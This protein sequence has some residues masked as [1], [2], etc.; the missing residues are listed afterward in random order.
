MSKDDTNVTEDYCVTFPFRKLSE[1]ARS[2]F[3]IYVELALENTY[4][5]TKAARANVAPKL[6]L[7]AML[8]SI[9]DCT[10]T[11]VTYR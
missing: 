2:C 10:F 4:S 6:N 7:N 5:D 8:F 11:L 1:G 3:L 9:R